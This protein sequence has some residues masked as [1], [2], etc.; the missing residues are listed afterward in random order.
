MDAGLLEGRRARRVRAPARPLRR[1]P[2]GPGDDRHRVHRA[3]AEATDPETDPDR[4]A[5][6]RARATPGPDEEVAAEL[7]RSAGRA[8]ARGGVAAAA[9]FLRARRRADGGSGAAGAARA[10]R[11]A[12][13]L[14]G[15]RARRGA[16]APGDG[17]GR[18][19]RR[20]RAR[21]GRP[22]CGD[23]S[24]SPRVAAGRPRRSSSTR[25]GSS[26]RSTRRLARE[27]YLEAWGAALRRPAPRRNG[28]PPEVCRAVGPS[29]PA[30][31]PARP[32][33]CCSTA[34]HVAVHRRLRRRGAGA[35]TRA[36]SVLTTDPLEDVMRWGWLAPVAPTCSYGTSR[37]CV[38]LR[39]GH[40]QLV[41]D[42]GALAQL[43]L[44]PRSA[45]HRARVEGDFA[46][47]A[48]LVA[49]ATA[50]ADG[51]R[52]QPAR[53]TRREARGAA[54]ARG[55]GLGGDRGAIEQ[56]AA[57][58][59][60]AVA[61]RASGRRGP[62]Q[63]PRPLRGGG[64]RRPRRARPRGSSLASRSGRCPSWSRRPRARESRARAATRSRVSPSDD[65]ARRTEWALGIEA[66]S[67]GAARRR[68]GRRRAL[69]RSD[70]PARPHAGCARSSPAHICSTGSGCAARAGASTRASSCAAAHDM[71]ATIGHGGVRRA[72][73]PRAAGDRREGAQARA[74]RRATSS[75]PQEEQI[76]RLARDG[77]SNP[78]IGAQLFLS[79]RT[80]EWHLRKV[81]TKLG[82]SSRRE[83]AGALPDDGPP[84]DLDHTTRRESR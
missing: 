4:R 57:G 25:R 3:L 81:F 13:E 52:E 36:R 21:P 49:E 83:L 66:R 48:A 41:R 17:G 84:R 1:L 53:P 43:P 5:W 64:W 9:A 29:R 72:R 35:E 59:R 23:G 44:A 33:T 14:P 67:P 24:H 61:L 26:S 19:A 79:S 2:L 40:V 37:A 50:I 34:W 76:A 18:A 68:R 56:A 80:V 22:R 30:G 42:A 78:E 28:G 7:E 45:G 62:L 39:T 10:R 54:G 71:L 8:Q 70:R 69:P 74:T 31:C 6:H 47:A 38:D 82:I 11:G 51:D 16:R 32:S 75:P 60:G 73:P 77:L 58:G 63:R 65:A 55:R 20:V 46:A 15:R 27:T 12:G